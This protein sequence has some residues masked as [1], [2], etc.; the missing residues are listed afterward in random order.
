MKRLSLII[1]LVCLMTSG[2]F[3]A[4]TN[5]WIGSAGPPDPNPAG[6]GEWSAN[7]A[8]YWSLFKLPDE[9]GSTSSYVK[10]PN[11]TACTLNSAAGNFSH[12]K[13]TVAGTTV[14]GG[15]T[16]NIIGGSI[17]TGN[18]FQVS[19][20]GKTGTIVQTGGSVTTFQG[21]TAGKLE[22]GYKAAGVGSWTIS[23]GSIGFS[24]PC[25]YGSNVGQMIIGGAGAAGSTGTFTVHGSA[26]TINT[27][28]FWVGTKDATGAY[29]GTGTVKFELTDGVSPINV[30][31]SVT[32][33]PCGAAACVANL[34]VALM[35]EDVPPPIIVLIKN[36]S[37]TAVSGTFDT[38][39]GDQT[40][41]DRALEGDTVVLTTPGNTSY[42]YTLTYL[43]N[44]DAG[45]I[46]NDIALVPEPATIALLSLGLLLVRR[47]RK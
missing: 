17:G 26:P 4:Q 9:D 47:N 35:D 10:V 20:A 13:L 1:F 11:L 45:A 3:A 5:N 46:G 2:A 16:L 37:A 41:W 19:D 32:I 15:S 7:P 12:T 31:T 42:T 23:G 8:T 6:T 27:D 14:G 40:P 28:K 29:P 24:D 39:S 43:Y 44:A 18:E 22:I 30:K 21:S 25:S 34:V 36:G 33:D 38:V